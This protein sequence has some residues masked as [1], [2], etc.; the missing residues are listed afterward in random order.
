[1]RQHDRADRCTGDRLQAG[2]RRPA[3]AADEPLEAEKGRVVFYEAVLSQSK[4]GWFLGLRTL[5]YF[6]V[7]SAV[8]QDAAKPSGGGIHSVHI[9]APMPVV[10]PEFQRTC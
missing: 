8:W 2:A 4:W 5:Q 9:T 1:M 3:A 7:H 6:A 10:R